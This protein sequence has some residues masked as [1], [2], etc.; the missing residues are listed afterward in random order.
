MEIELTNVCG[1]TEI[2]DIGFSRGAF[3]VS[4]SFSISDVRRLVRILK[5][6]LDELEKEIA[7]KPQPSQTLKELLKRRVK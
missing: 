7:K 3:Y 1:D 5:E 4:L 6:G 2:I